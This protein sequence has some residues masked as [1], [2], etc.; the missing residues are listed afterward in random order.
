MSKQTQAADGHYGLKGSALSAWET[1]AQSVANIAPTASPTVVI[2]LVFAMAGGGTWLAYLI[3][4]VSIIFVSWNI[5]Q[6]AKRSASP[7]SFYVYVAQG[8]GPTA[9][10]LVGW[11]L[12]I[13]YIGTGSA[14]TGGFTNY[15]HVLLLP[16]V[17][18]GDIPGPVF[19]VVFTAVAIFG[20]WFFAYKDVKLSARLMLAFEG[21]S[22]SLI[23]I[24]VGATIIRNGW[25]LDWIQLS[26][27]GV[28]ADQLRSGLVLAIFS[29]VGFESATS[30]GAEARNPLKTIPRAVVRSAIF[31]GLFFVVSSYGLVLGFHGESASLD[32]SSAPLNVLAGKA[33]LYV[34]EPLISAGAVISFFA[35]TL[36]SITAGARIL[37]LMARHGIFPVALGNAHSTNETPSIAVT[38]SSV[39][40]FVPAAALAIAGVGP[41]DIYGWVGAV[42]TYGFI[43]TYIA[44]SIAAPVELYKLGELTLGAVAVSGIAIAALATALV[45]NLYPVPPAPY[46][47]LPYLFLGYLALGWA[48]FA[49]AKSRSSKVVEEIHNDLGQIQKRFASE[50]ATE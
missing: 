8:L 12:L 33:G 18:G 48:W 47:W 17:G 4:L 11:A 34:L 5:N 15:L 20:A 27:Q 29:F 32:K 50:Q 35:C 38:V 41:F 28:S 23:A 49:I 31:V 46:N 21:I 25:H 36:A 1:F 43:V 26:L 7:G 19:S 44:I 30:L 13:A 40:A 45:G 2:P 6:F 14:V 37:F 24:I 16:I 42:A 39:L 10:V 22:V 9:G 3:A